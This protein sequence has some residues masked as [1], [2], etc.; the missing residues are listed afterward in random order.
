MRNVICPTFKSHCCTDIVIFYCQGHF[1]SAAL[2]TLLQLC[3]SVMFTSFLTDCSFFF[4]TFSLPCLASS[5]KNILRKLLQLF[6]THCSILLSRRRASPQKHP[7]LLSD[8]HRGCQ[9]WTGPWHCRPSLTDLILR[10]SFFIG[11]PF[12]QPVQVGSFHHRPLTLS[13]QSR[14]EHV[15]GSLRPLAVT[16]ANGVVASLDQLNS[17]EGKPC[18]LISSSSLAEMETWSAG[19]ET[20]AKINIKTLRRLTGPGGD[21]IPVHLSNNNAGVVHVL[22]PKLVPDGCEL[23]AMPQR[24]WPPR[25]NSFRPEPSHQL[26]PSP[27]ESPRISSAASTLQ[28]ETWRQSL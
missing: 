17:G 6:V 10:S 24:S 16:V 11:C 8:E 12:A 23:L 9:K 26:R 18:T 14:A 7:P 2:R 25:G 3:P 22:L 5:L 1:P 4:S 27:R 20:V 19:K 13:S 28:Q 21:V 15:F